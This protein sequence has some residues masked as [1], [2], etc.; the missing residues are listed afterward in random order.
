MKR[1]AAASAHK[2]NARHDAA[3]VVEE[4]PYGDCGERKP[5]RRHLSKCL[6]LHNTQE[7]QAEIH[8]VQQL[9]AA[10]HIMAGRSLSSFV[11][12]HTAA[13]LS[14]SMQDLDSIDDGANAGA[15]RAWIA[16]QSHAAPALFIPT[17]VVPLSHLQV[18]YLAR[19]LGDDD[20]DAAMAADAIPL[21]TYEPDAIDHERSIDGDAIAAAPFD[22]EARGRAQRFGFSAFRRKPVPSTARA[23]SHPGIA[24]SL[25]LPA[26]SFYE[27]GPGRPCKT[28]KASS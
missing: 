27:R 9:R 4:C 6:L 16:A 10:D 26:S 25:A 15:L 19:Q 12:S 17:A 1:K 7:E 3:A 8:R 14:N 23:S 21:A 24:A 28:I 11:S 5:S 22:F 2:P 20:D 13:G 18:Q